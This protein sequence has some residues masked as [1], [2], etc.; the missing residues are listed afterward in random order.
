MNSNGILFPYS[1]APISSFWI[2]TVLL[3]T[4]KGLKSYVSLSLPLI[5]FVFLLASI[6][7]CKCCH[8]L[9]EMS[10]SNRNR[11]V[12]SVNAFSYHIVNV[13]TMLFNER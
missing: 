3:L 5:S 13:T 6:R 2:W 12:K 11:A 7:T 8:K 9:F 4:V 10:Y 1:F